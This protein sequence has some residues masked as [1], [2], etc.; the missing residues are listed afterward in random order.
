MVTLQARRIAAGL[1]AAALWLVAGLPAAPAAAAWQVCGGTSNGGPAGQGTGIAAASRQ[2]VYSGASN[3]W[4][5]ATKLRLLQKRKAGQTGGGTSGGSG[6]TGSGNNSGGTSP[7]V[8]RPSTPPSG[9]PTTPDRPA[10]PTEP[11]VTR[12]SQPAGGSGSTTASLTA[13]ERRVV[14]LINRDRRARG[15]PELAVDPD[16][17]RLA[18]LKARDMQEKGYFSH[19]SPTYGWPYEMER[20]AG[21]RARVMGAE[22]IAQA[23]DADRAHMLFMASEGHRANILNPQHDSIGVAVVPIRYG[24]LV[25]QMFLG[26]R[27]Q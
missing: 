4:Y 22:N 6:G 11:P 14:E 13:E 2:A 25:V 20:N 15:L 8:P 23:R 1:L 5:Y 12:P 17:T 9:T 27:Y 7:Q 10:T 3:G 16:L 18:R 21:I 24:V 19:H 26:D